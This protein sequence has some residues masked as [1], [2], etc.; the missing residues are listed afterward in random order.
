M[1]ILNTLPNGVRLT[2]H[3]TLM[4]LTKIVQKKMADFEH[5]TEWGKDG[6]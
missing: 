2:H 6:A 5:P 3:N 4:I 1:R